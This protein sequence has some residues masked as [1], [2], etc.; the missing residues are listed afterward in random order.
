VPIR[1]EVVPDLIKKVKENFI[2]RV[3]QKHLS[4]FSGWR[5]DS[6]A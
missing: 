1:K 5:T 4:V 2:V 3:F 6:K